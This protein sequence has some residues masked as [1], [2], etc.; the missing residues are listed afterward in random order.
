MLEMPAILISG[1]SIAVDQELVAE[2]QYFSRVVQNIDNREIESLLVQARVQLILLEF[3]KKS[4]FEIEMIKKIN[5]KY[6]G[7]SILVFNGHGDRNLLAR[8]FHYGAKDAFHIPYDCKLVVERTHALLFDA[9][10]AKS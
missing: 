10:P 5:K 1:P 2:L 6:P 7:V 4:L 8:A 3:S 9:L